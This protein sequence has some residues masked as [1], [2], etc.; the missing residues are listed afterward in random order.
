[1]RR[2]ELSQRLEILRAVQ[3]GATLTVEREFVGNRKRRYYILARPD[4]APE[5]VSQ[6]VVRGLYC[7]GYLVYRRDGHYALTRRGQ[8]YLDGNRPASDWYL[9]GRVSLGPFPG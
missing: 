4:T 7:A 2:T 1:M 8:W 9:T 3:S 5:I 6:A